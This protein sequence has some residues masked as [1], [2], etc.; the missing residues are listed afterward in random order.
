[1]KPG[2]LRGQRW[3]GEAASDHSQAEAQLFAHIA[4]F[5]CRTGEM[6]GRIFSYSLLK[7]WNI[8]FVTLLLW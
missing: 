6:C 3:L 8:T 7:Q 5:S 2:P 4:K 1:V